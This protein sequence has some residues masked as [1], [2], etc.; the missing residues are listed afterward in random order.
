MIAESTAALVALLAAQN[1]TVYDDGVPSSPTY[2][3]VALWTDPGT[4]DDVS[5][6]AQ[7]EA[8]DLYPRLTC[9]G[10]NK[11]Q[12]RALLDRVYAVD[13]Q[14]LSWPGWSARVEVSS[15]TP[16]SQDRDIPD[17]LVL[18]SSVTLALHALAD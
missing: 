6:E 5:V 7:R 10:V 12:V 3:Y 2:P 1:V 16:I 9:A 18:F 4:R 14:W 17:R 11:A 8:A 15:S 13:G